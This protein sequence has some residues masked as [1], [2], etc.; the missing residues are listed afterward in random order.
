MIHIVPYR[1][2]HAAIFKELNLR[3]LDRFGLTESHDLEILD[4]PQGTVIDAGGYI[5]L[6]TEGERVIGTAAIIKTGEKDF[7][8]AKMTVDED[9]R[10]KGISKMLI[11]KCIAQAV[12]S[13][14]THL[15][16]FS[17]HQLKEAIKLYEKYGFQHTPM[18]KGPFITADVSM[19]LDLTSLPANK[20]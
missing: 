3:W 10:G 20:I 11:E 6:A 19:E 12:S 7:E 9:Y 14:A 17:N 16:L 1:H 2:E 5:F 18:K 8:L 15:H 4:D 13:G